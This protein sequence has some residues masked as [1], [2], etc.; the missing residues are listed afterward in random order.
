[1][2]DTV[3]IEAPNGDRWTV[4]YTSSKQRPRTGLGKGGGAD[5]SRY[6]RGLL[7]SYANGAETTECILCGDV[8]GTAHDVRLPMGDGRTARLAGAEADRVVMG[9]PGWTVESA[10][11]QAPYTP[12][13]V[14]P[15][16]RTCNGNGAERAPHADRL[17]A[18]ARDL[19]DR[20]ADRV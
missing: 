11:G 2:T 1:M 15:A 4:P 6:N 12:A 19:L 14:A 10:S 17:A 3:T 7:R 13:T 9:L 20:H 5:V 16:C 18:I 8:I